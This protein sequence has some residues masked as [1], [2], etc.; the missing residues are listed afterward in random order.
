MIQHTILETSIEYSTKTLWQAQIYP[1]VKYM[2]NKT[3]SLSF[4]SKRAH[5]CP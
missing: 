3:T 1:Y 2:N 4:T 5:K